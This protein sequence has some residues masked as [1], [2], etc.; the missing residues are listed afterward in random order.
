MSSNVNNNLVPVKESV[1][2]ELQEIRKARS[3]TNS[4]NL[5]SIEKITVTKSN[6]YFPTIFY[7]I[8]FRKAT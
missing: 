7:L 8:L 5:D 3:S 1:S 2:N 4:K 6:L